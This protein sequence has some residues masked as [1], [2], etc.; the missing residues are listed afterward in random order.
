[1][2]EYTNFENVDL[3]IFKLYKLLSDENDLPVL[4]AE[5]TELD[6]TSGYKEL[7]YFEHVI[8]LQTWLPH[9][10]LTVE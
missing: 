8:N 4:P 9:F 7:H 1:M 10:V 5:D 2:E 3:L 6:T